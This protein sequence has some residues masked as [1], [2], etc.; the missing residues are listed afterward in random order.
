MVE[1]PIFKIYLKKNLFLIFFGLILSMLFFSLFTESG[2]MSL[3]SYDTKL[4][5]LE[6]SFTF[7]DENIEKIKDQFT[8][9][10]AK[11]NVIGTFQFRYMSS[12]NIQR[13][14]SNNVLTLVS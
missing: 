2:D 4:K 8:E 6:M 5:Q 10:K 12:S 9:L 14:S 13:D 7:L 1:T 11:M 3:M